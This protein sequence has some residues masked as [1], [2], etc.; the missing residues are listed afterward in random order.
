[1]L[2]D[3]STLVKATT[4]PDFPL[5]HPSQAPD[6][7]RWKRRGETSRGHRLCKPLLTPSRPPSLAFMSQLS[8]CPWGTGPRLMPIP[9][10]TTRVDSSD[11][12]GPDP[13]LEVGRLE[14]TPWP[15]G[16]HHHRP[17]T[18][19]DA[20]PCHCPTG[21]QSG[22]W[23]PPLTQEPRPGTEL[24]SPQLLPPPTPTPGPDHRGCCPLPT[25]GTEAHRGP[26]T[27]SRPQQSFQPHLHPR[28]SDLAPGPPW[29]S[30]HPPMIHFCRRRV[31]TQTEPGKNPDIP[32]RCVLRV[33]PRLGTIQAGAPTTAVHSAPS[34]R[35]ALP[36]PGA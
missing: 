17:T 15:A 22:T 30:L 18:P 14:P 12:Q 35:G 13:S 25:E 24:Q 10:L 28:P 29:N 19:H 6:P 20:R 36:S 27:T 1:M 23:A 3:A 2:L 5:P 4:W 16:P 33:T 34:P 8:Q 7:L 26:W 21:S 31:Q 32:G 11:S 9:S